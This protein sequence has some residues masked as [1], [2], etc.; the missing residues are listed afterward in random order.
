MICNLNL[1]D[2]IQLKLLDLLIKY[3]FIR[4]L[5]QLKLF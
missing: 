2:T 5:H 1:L 4:S 3:K